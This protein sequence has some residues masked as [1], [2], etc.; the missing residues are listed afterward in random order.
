MATVKLEVLTSPKNA[1]AHTVK[2]VEYFLV[3]L[4][5]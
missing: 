1:K 3:V 4:Q 2:Y 5:F